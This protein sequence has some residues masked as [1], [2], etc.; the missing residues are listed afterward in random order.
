[1]KAVDARC[2]VTS[3][4]RHSSSVVTNCCVGVHHKDVEQPHFGTFNSW[5]LVFLLNTDQHIPTL[6]VAIRDQVLHCVERKW[7]Q[8]S[9]VAEPRRHGQTTVLM[10]A[11][12]W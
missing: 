2:I 12:K 8:Q 4:R 5:S 1:M 3:V 10:C 9:R 7:V 6:R 11:A